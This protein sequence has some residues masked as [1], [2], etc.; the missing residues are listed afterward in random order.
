MVWLPV[1]WRPAGTKI[2]LVSDQEFSHVTTE[3]FFL[4]QV[5]TVFLISMLE[6]SFPSLRWLKHFHFG[7]RKLRTVFPHKT[8]CKLHSLRKH[9]TVRLTT[10]Y[11]D[12]P[13]NIP[14]IRLLGLPPPV[15]EDDPVSCCLVII[16]LETDKACTA[17]SHKCDHPSHSGM[18]SISDTTVGIGRN[19][20]LAETYSQCDF[21][22]VQLV[23]ATSL[24]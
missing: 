8:F 10:M 13:K 3:V 12:F 21:P 1:C 14:S 11:E 20:A 19:L 6:P 18:I 23:A 16:A 22:S 2:I 4:F 9:H 7:Y 5:S 24:G 15:E 17:L